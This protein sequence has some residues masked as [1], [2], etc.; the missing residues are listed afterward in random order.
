VHDAVRARV[1]RSLCTDD[2]ELCIVIVIKHSRRTCKG[3]H[4]PFGVT[5]CAPGTRVFFGDLFS[6]SLTRRGLPQAM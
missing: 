3:P 5:Y 2:T 1:D 6:S 4:T